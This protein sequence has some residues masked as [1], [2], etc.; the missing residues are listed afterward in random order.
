VR[1]HFHGADI[2]LFFSHYPLS[3]AF[4]GPVICCGPAAVSW[5]THSDDGGFWNVWSFWYRQPPRPVCPRKWS[6]SWS[7]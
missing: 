7:L 6:W 4:I 2:G 5:K 1:E 3:R